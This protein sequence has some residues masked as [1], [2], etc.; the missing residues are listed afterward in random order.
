MTRLS[1]LSKWPTATRAGFL[2]PWSL[3][4]KRPRRA[5]AGALHITRAIAEDSI[6]QRAVLYDKDGDAHYDTI[7]AFIKSVRGSDPDAALYWMAKMLYA[8]EDPRFIFRRMLILAC[9]DVGMADPGRS[10]VVVDAARAFD[11]VGLPEGRYHLAHACLYLSTAPKSNSSMAFFDALGVVSR[12]GLRRRPGPSCAM[13]AA[14]RKASATAKGTCIRTRIATT[15]WHSNTFRKRSRERSFTSPPSRA[16]KRAYGT[17]SH[18]TGKRR[19]KPWLRKNA[20]TPS[21]CRPKRPAIRNPGAT[22]GRSV[23]EASTVANWRRYGTRSW[24]W[25][26]SGTTTLRSIYTRALAFWR[27]KSAAGPGKAAC[28]RLPMTNANSRP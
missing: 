26:P 8:G 11:Y 20:L 12:G 23:R 7:S 15:G 4:W 21:K 17:G 3:P 28:G 5:M 6:Q 9:E 1:I 18:V 10:G 19:L 2:T 13:R 16:M 14:T 25:P 24:K 27:L 22:N